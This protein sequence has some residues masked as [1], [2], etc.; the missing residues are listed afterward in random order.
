M[1]FASLKGTAVR[2]AASAPKTLPRAASD[3]VPR[4][5]RSAHAR[6]TRDGDIRFGQAHGE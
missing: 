3:L 5:K 4:K 1:S 6:A 2:L